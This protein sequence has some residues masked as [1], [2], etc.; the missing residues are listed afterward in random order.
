MLKTIAYKG[1]HWVV[2]IF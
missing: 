2:Y 1:K